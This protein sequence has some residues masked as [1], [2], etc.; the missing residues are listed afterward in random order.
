MKILSGIQPTGNLHIGN[1]LGALKQWKQMHDNQEHETFFSVVDLHA[2]T[3]IKNKD[4]L[5]QNIENAQK[6]LLSLGL[7]NTLFIQSQVPQHTQ[8]YWLLSTVTPVGDLERM[9]QFKDKKAQGLDTNSGLFSYPILMAADILLYKT[10]LVPVGEDQVQHIELTRTIARK[11]NTTY[12]EIFVQPKPMIVEQ[13]AR[14]MS[15]KDPTKKMSKSLGEA[16]YVG[17]FESQESI[18]EKFKKATTDSDDKIIYD[19]NN[20]HGV[21]NLLAIYAGFEDISAQQAQEHF[22][23]SSYASLKQEVANAVIQ[24]LEPMRE[25]FLS[26]SSQ[27]IR[28]SFEQGK[29]TAIQQAQQTLEQTYTSVG[30]SV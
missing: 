28:D 22:S 3:V 21:S 12:S 6:T 11:F 7:T 20:K 10:E 17:M 27:H 29:Q 23:S 19:P 4:V 8:L 5:Q 18:Q 9:T 15:L 13:N 30:I 1:Y 25:T 14:I 24:R 2:L 26:L 16:H